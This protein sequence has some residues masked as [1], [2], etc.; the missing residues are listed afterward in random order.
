M[1]AIVRE[2]ARE[3][4]LASGELEKVRDAH[5]R[6]FLD[7]GDRV[8]SQLKGERQREWLRRLGDERDNLR[9]AERF[10]LS[11][12]DWDRAAHLAFSLYLYWWVAGLLGEVRTWMDEALES[13]D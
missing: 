8:E 10:L 7:L 9:A 2:Y 6:F 13:R 12:R 11:S 4:L 1:Q 5:A 3:Q